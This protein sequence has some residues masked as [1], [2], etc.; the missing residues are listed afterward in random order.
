VLS[1]VGSDFQSRTL[2]C[3]VAL[4]FDLACCFLFVVVVAV[5]VVVVSAAVVLL[6]HCSPRG[7]S[8]VVLAVFESRS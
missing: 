5:V 4:L 2:G 8:K 7:C 3:V 1:F 6:L